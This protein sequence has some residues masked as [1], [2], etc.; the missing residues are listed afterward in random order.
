MGCSRDTANADGRAQLAEITPTPTPPS[1]TGW[2]GQNIMGRI[3]RAAARRLTLPL[4]YYLIVLSGLQFALRV[5]YRWALGVP[6]A[7]GFGC[8]FRPRG[9]AER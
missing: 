4:G 8:V 7:F 1:R 5:E 6:R 3:P 9:S 2:E